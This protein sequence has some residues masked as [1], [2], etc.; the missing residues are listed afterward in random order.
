MPHQFKSVHEFESKIIQPIGRTW[1]PEQK[2]KKLT[3][4]KIKTKLG[5]I[6]EPIDK[7]DIIVNNI[8]K[9]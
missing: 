5:S 9:K 3:T 7:D 4:R 2:F 1:N 6:I 8:K